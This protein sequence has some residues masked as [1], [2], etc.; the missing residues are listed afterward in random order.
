MDSTIGAVEV[1]GHRDQ[2]S[3]SCRRADVRKILSGFRFHAFLAEFLQL[4]IEGIDL[5]VEI[6]EIPLVGEVSSNLERETDDGIVPE[7]I[8]VCLSVKAGDWSGAR[9]M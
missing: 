6:V 9:R 7:L 3:D 5:G 2:V 4:V 1:F 8:I